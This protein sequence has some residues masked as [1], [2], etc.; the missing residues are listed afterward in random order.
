MI[1]AE[2]TAPKPAVAEPARSLSMQPVFDLD[3]DSLLGIETED[4]KQGGLQGRFQNLHVLKEN[5]FE[6]LS[7]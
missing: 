2:S 4:R 7:T 5:A 3:P 6:T 1:L